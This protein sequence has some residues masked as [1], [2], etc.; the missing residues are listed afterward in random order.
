MVTA[1]NRGGIH[2]VR[3]SW[4]L[5][6][7]NVTVGLPTT[8]AVEATVWIRLIAVDGTVVEAGRDAFPLAA[9]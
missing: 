7:Y 4:T 1:S 9:R 6:V 8:L 5:R 3:V 2:D